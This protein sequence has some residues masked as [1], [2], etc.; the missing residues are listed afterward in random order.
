MY[1]ANV[2]FNNIS[3]ISWQSVLLMEE[4]EV[5]RENYRPAA[6]HWLY[7][8]ILSR[9]QLSMSRIRTI[10]ASGDMNWLH[11]TTPIWQRPQK[12]TKN[13]IKKTKTKTKT[14][15]N[16]PKNKNKQATKTQK[17]TQM[18]PSSSLKLELWNG[19]SF[20]LTTYLHCLVDVWFIRQSEF[21]YGNNL[22]SSSH[23]LFPIFVRGRL[24]NSYRCFLNKNKKKL[25][26]SFNFT[27]RY[28][29]WWICWSHVSQ[30]AYNNGFRRYRLLCF[31]PWPTRRNEQW[32]SIEN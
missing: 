31:I 3:V 16:K 20:C 10:N 23:R 13:K 11:N 5:F 27:F 7:H 30:R 2:T 25:G 32:V 1:G 29:A 21:L 18:V 26:R 4:T 14:K 28:K 15:T 6:K 24:I 22:C 12:A 17:D 19:S 9:V 8:T